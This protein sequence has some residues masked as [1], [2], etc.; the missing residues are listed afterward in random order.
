ST[1]DVR[2]QLGG[3]LSGVLP[4]YP[5][6]IDPDPPIVGN[7]Q[8]RRALL[9]G[10]DRQELTN[11]LND[12]LGPI[13]QSWVQSDQPE[14]RA[15]EDRVVHYAFDTRGAGQVLEGLGYVR[16][17]DGALQASDGTRLSV[18]LM[19]HEQNSFH[20]PTTLAV[21]TAWQKLGLDVQLDVIPA[22]R[23]T[24]VK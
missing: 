8:F 19:T 11:E 10:I 16:G 6:F 24:D 14:G 17:A 20:V 9:M 2:V 5:Q 12:G 23:A 15:I 4:I 7:V 22:A 13:A 3:T 18:G 1:Q 21:Q